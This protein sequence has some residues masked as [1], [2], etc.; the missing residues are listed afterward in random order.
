MNIL[1]ELLKVSGMEFAHI[2][3]TAEQKR[4]EKGGFDKGIYN[5]FVEI[6][7]GHPSLGYYRAQPNQ[8]PELK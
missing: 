2:Q 8:Y 5:A 7:E 1:K 3:Q 6:E 4:L